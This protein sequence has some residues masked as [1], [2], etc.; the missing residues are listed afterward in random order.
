M[1]LHEHAEFRESLVAAARESGLP[2]QFIEKDYYVTEILRI[3]VDTHR[4]R[5]IF[6][7]GTS[8]FKGWRLIDRYSED[9]DLF[10]DPQAFDPHL[11]RRA[12]DRELERLRDAVG[13]HPALTHVTERSQRSKGFSRED[14]FSY[15]SIVPD[16]LL[17]V[18]T[19]V[20][21]EP[22]IQSGRQPTADCEISSLVSDFLRDQGAG[23]LADDLDPFQMT[24]LHFRR[25]FVEKLF[26][27]HGKVERLKD[28]AEPLGRDARHYADLH[29]LAGQAEIATMLDSE[30]YEQI[31]RD[32]DEH[33]R[34]YFAKFYRPPENLNLSSSDALFPPEE[35]RAQI[36]PDYDRECQRLFPAGQSY[37]AFGEVI[38]RLEALRPNLWRA[39]P[40]A[41]VA[42]SRTL[43]DR[44][45]LGRPLRRVTG[46]GY[47]AE[48]CP[49]ASRPGTEGNRRT[50]PSRDPQEARWWRGSLHAHT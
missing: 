13:A 21:L 43:G 49:P 48:A 17:P 44:P 27:I 8:L 47:R 35:L 24:L 31:K 16:P 5:T 9:I 1:R 2:E 19:A 7:G 38:D 6:K 42:L 26:T 33:S 41:S 36:E 39:A 32:Y 23:D 14:L 10:L 3:V 50:T 20:L 30:E 37:P 29:A 25:T 28:E 12:V 40:C 15:E 46:L 11:G 22:G 4:G 34:R 18:D 45:E